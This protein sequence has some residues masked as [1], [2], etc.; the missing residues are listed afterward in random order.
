[1]IESPLTIGWES[2]FGFAKV[3]GFASDC[4]FEFEFVK[5]SDSGYHFVSG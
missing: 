2:D 3:F 4:C 1:M 5:L